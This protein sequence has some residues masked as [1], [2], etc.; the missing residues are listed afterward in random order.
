MLLR[1]GKRCAGYEVR[2]LWVGGAKS[3][4][5]LMPLSVCK[6]YN[7]DSRTLCHKTLNTIDSRDR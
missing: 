3:L 4:T 6:E 5:Y 2:V 7:E 1:Y